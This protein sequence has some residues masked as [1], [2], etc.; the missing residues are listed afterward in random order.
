[1]STFQTEKRTLDEWFAL[2]IE[3]RQSGL[4]DVEWCRRNNIN[5]QSFYTAVKR[6]RK[7][8]YAVPPRSVA[9]DSG[10]ETL[11]AMPQDV[12]H[13][14]MISKGKPQLLSKGTALIES[15]ATIEID[16]PDGKIRIQNGVDPDLI[17]ALITAIGRR[18]S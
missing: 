14:G 15:Q 1:M 18:H 13:V 5:P 16:Y 11:P 12:V 4:S 2:V 17:T 9:V 8:S 3:A 7:K 6:L 10:S